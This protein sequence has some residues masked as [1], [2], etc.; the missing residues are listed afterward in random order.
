MLTPGA[1]A[2]LGSIYLFFTYATLK[3][4]RVEERER[5]R[6]RELPTKAISET[7]PIGQPEMV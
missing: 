3:A 6:F 4:K 5:G 7:K 2:V 1:I